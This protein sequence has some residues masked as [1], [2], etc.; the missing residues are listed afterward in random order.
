MPYLTQAVDSILGQ[1]Y[2]HLELVLVD[3]GSSDASSEWLHGLTD[4]RIQVH[5]L[6]QGTSAAANWTHATRLA[7]GE[8]VKLLCQDDLLAPDTLA[9]QVTHLVE[10]PE[11]DLTIGTRDIIS[12]SGSVLA[13]RRGLQ[14]LTEGTCSGQDTLRTCYVTGINVVGEPHTVLFRRQCLEDAMPW[15]GRRPFLLDLD[16][17]SKIL[18]VPGVKAW[19]CK[20]SVGAFRVS[21]SSWSTRL[22][23]DQQA[24]FRSWQNDFEAS[25]SPGLLERTRARL[26]TAR[27]TLTRRAAYA[28]LR[29]RGDFTPSES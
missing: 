3:G 15:E 13:R 29:A 21:A 19:L 4:S 27:Q 26:G 16:T 10:H 22:V 18:G 11:C 7:R 17:Y 14:G 2:P 5:A 28:Y 8:F 9:R 6:P 24:Q 12:A 23:S 25:H 20:E 1:T